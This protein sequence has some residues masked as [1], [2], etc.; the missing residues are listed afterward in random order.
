MRKDPFHAFRSLLPTIAA[1]ALLHP[2]V[3]A[4]QQTGDRSGLNPQ[5][6]AAKPVETASLRPLPSAPEVAE[7]ATATGSATGSEAY[8]MPALQVVSFTGPAAES[9]SHRFWDCEN[10]V[11]FALNAG[12]AAADF[13]VTRANLANGGQELNP[14]TRIMTGSTPALAANFALETGGVIAVSYLFHKTGHHQLER[15]TSMVNF[16]G[17]IAAVAYGATHR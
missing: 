13:S 7:S 8:A 2:A 12:A 5:A 6:S 14:V 4:G 9:A 1:V 17:S 11:L 15:V 16:S 3:L 10:S